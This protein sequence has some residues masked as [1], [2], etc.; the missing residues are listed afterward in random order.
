MSSS[1]RWLLC[2][3]TLAA[4]P[5]LAAP[6]LATDSSWMVTAAPA[7][8][9]W[10]SVVAFDDSTWSAATAIYSVTPYYPAVV[11]DAIWGPG[12]QFSRSETAIWGRRVWNL[13]AVPTSALLFGGID[14]DGDVYVNGQWV[15]GSHDGYAGN[16]GPVD[17]T[18][19]LVAG[20][21]LIAFS[22][23]DNWMSWGYNHVIWM[24]VD[25]QH[26]T[27]VP[28]PAS[29]GLAALGLGALAWRRQRRRDGRKSAPCVPPIDPIP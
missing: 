25:G 28:E 2:A 15:M 7:A 13:A 12:G 27:A 23:T 19:Y 9:G 6:L 24:Q 16:I 18:P 17:I 3:A 11:A 5:A 21:N 29:V 10:N 26:A 14:D 4:A 22:A 1:S 20:D 8:A